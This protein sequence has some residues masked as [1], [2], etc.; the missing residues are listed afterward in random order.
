MAPTGVLVGLVRPC[1]GSR[2]LP[3]S[4]VIPGS[5]DGRDL[6]CHLFPMGLGVQRDG[7]VH[8]AGTDC[9]RKQWFTSEGLVIG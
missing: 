2:A 4:W 9:Y 7:T 8:V 5:I 6:A 3:L 1:C